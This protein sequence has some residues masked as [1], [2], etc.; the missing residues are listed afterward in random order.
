MVTWL[1][2]KLVGRQAYFFFI[3]LVVCFSIDDDCEIDFFRVYNTLVHGGCRS[4]S[5]GKT[6]RA[7][8]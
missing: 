2:G 5:G 1:V 8:S 3:I 4:S 6:S 7:R